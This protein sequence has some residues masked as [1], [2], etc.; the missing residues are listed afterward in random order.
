M[1]EE[2]KCVRV[3]ALCTAR[4]PAPTSR[5]DDG[6]KASR[7]R[8]LWIR[9]MGS[10]RRNTHLCVFKICC[11]KQKHGLV[12]PGNKETFGRAAPHRIQRG[13]AQIYFKSISNRFQIDFK[14]ISYLFRIDFNFVSNSNS[15]GPGS[16]NGGD[17]GLQILFQHPRK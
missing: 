2:N 14:F 13:R 5:V 1:T 15:A 12:F 10:R 16:F 7:P 9:R 11:T 4:R 6:A 8:L 3:I 17:I